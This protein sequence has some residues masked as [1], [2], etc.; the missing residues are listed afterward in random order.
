MCK[1]SFCPSFFPMDF[2]LLA[3]FCHFGKLTA[4]ITGKFA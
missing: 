4:G 2:E 1:R 3:E